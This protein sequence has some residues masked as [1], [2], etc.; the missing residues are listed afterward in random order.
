M[1]HRR[2]RRNARRCDDL[3]QNCLG[4]MSGRRGDF[5]LR[6]PR[7]EIDRRSECPIR[8][9]IRNLGRQVNGYPERDT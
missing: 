5:Q 2:R 4:Q 6:L 8:T 1:H 3:R 7:D 9:V